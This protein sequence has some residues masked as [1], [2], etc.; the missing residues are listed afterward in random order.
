MNYEILNFSY[1]WNKKLYCNFF[2]TIRLEN[3]NKYSTGKKYRIFLKNLH[4]K[5]A[6]IVEIKTIKI[7]KINNFIAGIDTG[8]NIETCIEIIKK[9]YPKSNWN[10]QKIYF[11][12][13]KTIDRK[14]LL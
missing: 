13:L 12:L 8:Y 7:D 5:D 3:P 14:T 9:M 6:E 1:D 11:I 2:T 4:I 10:T